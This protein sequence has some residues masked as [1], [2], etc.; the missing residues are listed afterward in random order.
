M[1]EDQGINPLSNASMK[2]RT[3]ITTYHEILEMKEEGAHKPNI[4]AT[5]MVAHPRFFCMGWFCFYFWGILILTIILAAAGLDPLNADR[6]SDVSL[7]TPSDTYTQREQA[8]YRTQNVAD[9]YTDVSNCKQGSVNSSITLIMRHGTGGNILNQ[10]GLKKM[11]SVIDRIMSKDGVSDYC[12]LQYSEC[13][14]DNPYEKYKTS[15]GCCVQAYVN[16]PTSGSTG[17]TYNATTAMGCSLPRSPVAYFQKYGDPTFS[18]ISGTLALIEATSASD[19]ANLVTL[20]GKD[21]DID[22]ST[23]STAMIQVYFA[24]PL[25]AGNITCDTDCEINE[26]DEVKDWI[27]ETYESYL[28]KIFDEDPYQFLYTY[29]GYDPL[30]AIVLADMAKVIIGI[31]LLGIYMCIILQSLFL[32]A[33]ALFQSFM[34]FLGGNLI[35]R[36]LWPTQSG[37]GYEDNFILFCAL[38]IFIILGVG[39]DDVF[40]FTDTWSENS[41]HDKMDVAQRFSLTYL[42]AGKAM[43][44][45]SLTT[46]ICFFSNIASA[47]TNI[48]AFGT[49]AGLIIAVNYLMVMS[50]FPSCVI[51]YHTY[52]KDWHICGTK[53]VPQEANSDKYTVEGEILNQDEGETSNKEEKGSCCSRFIAQV[54]KFDLTAFFLDTYAPGLFRF[55]LAVL[56]VFSA[57]IFSFLVCACLVTAVPFDVY[58]LVSPGH[59]F[60]EFYKS[61][62][63][64]FPSSSTPL[65]SYIVYGIDVEDPIEWGNS[66]NEYQFTEGEYGSGTPNFDLAFDISSTVSQTQQMDTC[67]WLA[68]EHEFRSSVSYK[69]MYIDTT[70]GVNPQ[71]QPGAS[72]DSTSAVLGVQCLMDALAQYENVS[73][74]DA[75]ENM[76]NAPIPDC[77]VGSAGCCR[78]CFSNFS[79][80]V[81]PVNGKFFSWDNYPSIVLNTSKMESSCNCMGVFPIPTQICLSEMEYLDSG[82]PFQCVTQYPTNFLHD[83][84]AFL[85][86]DVNPE[87]FD[88]WKSSIWASTDPITGHFSRVSANW[89]QVQTTMSA[90]E[91]DFLT[92]MEMVRAWDDWMEVYNNHVKENGGHKAMIFIPQATTWRSTELLGPSAI[93]NTV[94]SLVLAFLILILCTGNYIVAVLAITTVSSIVIMIFGILYIFG[95]NLGIL[96]G[97]C[98]VLIVGF[99]VDFTIHLADSYVESEETTRYDKVREALGTTGISIISGSI[100]TLLATFPMLF[101][102]ISFFSKFGIFMFVTMFLSTAFSLGF[103]AALLM[104]IGPLGNQGLLSNFYGPFIEKAYLSLHSRHEP[105]DT[106]NSEL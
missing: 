73:Q 101:A 23:T 106:I 36:Y 43:F 1:D 54:R 59:N 77:S 20:L 99:S 66:F 32:T 96:E 19:Y 56:G 12:Y 71:L 22:D 72:V 55:R 14:N 13:N 18:D 16:L 67:R 82:T 57:L 28:L 41:K 27:K 94:L 68:T 17:G 105:K 40:V 29:T 69:H 52:L 8:F 84:A 60:H 9:Y 90:H 49:F 47:F 39:A 21:Y 25:H 79:M 104:T 58:T 88:W 97:I 81:A 92:G 31:I 61:L 6:I 11:E 53:T 50:F 63:S 45:T 35:Y 10:K 30:G 34:S 44:V 46:V 65:Y 15:P 33:C 74:Y 83:L 62:T 86:K 89:I 38:S 37:I 87:N 4:F 75:K 24:E 76:Y 80:D 70:Y 42:G 5:M 48:A 26:H 2:A 78:N 7:A 64:D 85:R 51:Y 91:S 102:T 93:S 3:S 98:C 103:M 100:S 95:W